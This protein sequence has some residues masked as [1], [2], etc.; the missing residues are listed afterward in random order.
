MYKFFTFL[1]CGYL[2]LSNAQLYLKPGNHYEISWNNNST[3]ELNLALE[4][5]INNTWVRHLKND[6]SYLSIILDGHINNYDWYI[7]LELSDYWM[8]TSRILVNDGNDIILN[9]QFSFYG[10]S[11]EHIPDQ[12]IN[13]TMEI[14]WNTNLDRNFSL[15]LYN[16]KISYNIVSN[17]KETFYDFELNNIPEGIYQIGI[18]YNYDLK[19]DDNI[20]ILCPGLCQEG[21]L[22]CCTKMQGSTLSNKFMVSFE[23]DTNDPN[24]TNEPNDDDYENNKLKECLNDTTCS[25]VFFLILIILVLIFLFC[26]FF[27]CCK[28]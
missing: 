28:S 15:Y 19:N 20:F 14:K 9:K 3:E 10:L 24:D 8:Y 17:Y 2:T 21:D 5:N 22:D 4:L 23:S 1:L 6:F 12:A 26:L 7:P 13:D 27:C 25:G 16:D 11:I 18:N